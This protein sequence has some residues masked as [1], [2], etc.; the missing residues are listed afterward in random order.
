[1]TQ[2]KNCLCAY[3]PH[4]KDSWE[5]EGIAPYILANEGKYRSTEILVDQGVS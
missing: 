4:H 3:I 5:S 1:M 2:R